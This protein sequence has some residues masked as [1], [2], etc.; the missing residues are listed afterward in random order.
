MSQLKED[1]PLAIADGGLLASDPDDPTTLTQVL[2]KAAGEIVGKSIIYLRRDGTEIVQ[3][4]PELLEEAQ[5][6]LAGL[7]KEGL[8]PQYKVILQLENNWD[9]IPAFWGS[10]LGG[11]VV[12]QDILC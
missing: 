4:Y 9:I 8:N 2:E 5:K 10:I 3:S 12:L 7:R 11:F 6:I 1:I